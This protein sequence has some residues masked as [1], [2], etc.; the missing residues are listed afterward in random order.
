MTRI[1]TFL[2]GYATS[3]SHGF[4]I[5]SIPGDRITD[6]V[7]CFAGFV[8][9]GS[10]WLPAFP[11][12]HDTEPGQK[13]NV[14]QLAA[15]K[16]RYPALN[17]VISI[18]GWNHSHQGDPTFKTTPPFTAVAATEA[19]RKAFVQQCLALFVTPQRPGIGTLFTG[20]DIDWE[21]PS[22]DQL[23]NLVLL[24]QEFRSQLDAAGATLGRTLT[25]SACFGAGDDYE[26]S[27]FAPLA[28]TLDWFNLM[29]YL[30][31]WPVADGR[32]TT[33]DF[34]APLYRSP[35]EPHANVTWT[36][37]GV[38]QSF[39]A[40]GIP[41]DKLVIGINTFGRTYAG[42]PNVANGLYQPYTGPGPGS[43]GEAGAL[44]YA[45]LVASY[46]PSYGHFFDPW[47]QSDYLYSPSAEVWISYDG[48]E[49]IHYRASYVSDL[50]LGGLLLWELSTDVPSVRSDGP[51]HATA[52]IDAM[53][54]GIAGFANQATLHQTGA[55]GP[56][57]AV[58]SGQVFLATNRPKEGVL[59]IAH[60]DD[61][62][63]SFGGT[64]VSQESSDA[65]PSLAT[66]GGQLKIGWRGAGNQNLNV[67]TV[68][69][70]NRTTGQPQIVGLSGKVVLDEFS[71]F[72]PA[73]VA[74]GEGGS[75]PSALVLAWTRAGDGRLCFRIST[76]GG[77]EF[78]ARFVSNEISA[79]GPSLAVWNGRVYVAWR[80]WGTNQTLNLASLII[81]PGTTQVTGL[82]NTIVLPGGS[83]AAPALTSDGNRLILAWKDGS[84]AVNVSMSLNGN[85]WFG[86]YAAPDMTGDSPALACDGFQ[87]PIAWRGSGSQQMNVAQV[88]SY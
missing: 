51:L 65:A 52:L 71:D 2:P 25:L 70:A 31:H 74:L 38:V 15:L 42:V 20:I 85:V 7:Y 49:G 66:N 82:G 81:E 62:G 69:V 30:A 23:D 45:D 3:A 54:R 28:K 14:A 72:T 67:A 77:G 27:A 50:G 60:S 80:G 48:P 29:T 4:Q 5:D 40:A 79:A 87:V 17:I 55:A 68:D 39:L 1:V 33:T 9:Q 34:G 58:Y 35:G 57:L 76:D 83:D 61:L 18:G 10:E 75:F 37:D 24:L 63:V 86:A 16:T 32:N 46:L 12:P 78:W 41:A 36:I 11:E 19:A 53:P 84:G 26:P 73:L 22:P 21:Y 13:H 59:E 43:R 44:D 56:A 47:T 8:Q 6:L 64:Y 88:A